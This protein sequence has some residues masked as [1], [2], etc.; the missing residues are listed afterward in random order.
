MRKLLVS[1]LYFES[2]PNYAL[3]YI[4]IIV[5][6][7]LA[8]VSINGLSWSTTYN[9]HILLTWNVQILAEQLSTICDFTNL[10]VYFTF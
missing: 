1:I 3:A 7:L 5:R 9:G 2:S 10:F 4:P 8:A 6:L